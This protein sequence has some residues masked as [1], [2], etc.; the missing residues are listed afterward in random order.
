MVDL[1]SGNKLVLAIANLAAIGSAIY[2]LFVFFRFIWRSG[3]K[4][5]D[6]FHRHVVR[7]YKQSILVTGYQIAMDAHFLIIHCIRSTILILMIIIFTVGITSMPTGTRE[8]FE[9]SVKAKIIWGSY[10][11]LLEFRKSLNL[12]IAVS[13]T[14]NILAAFFMFIYL[15]STLR[16]AWRFR[17]KWY[18][19]RKLNWTV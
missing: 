3:T 9:E 15:N 16:L 1:F 5:S 19:R 11:N 10:E 4:L 6:G 17:A 2:F 8:T 12:F 14:I 13:A 18:K 7:R